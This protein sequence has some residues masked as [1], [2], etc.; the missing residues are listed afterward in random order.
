MPKGIRDLVT[1]HI[2][3]TVTITETHQEFMIGIMISSTGISHIAMTGQTAI[4]STTLEA[5]MVMRI[6]TCHTIIHIE[7]LAMAIEARI[8][9]LSEMGHRK[10]VR[11]HPRGQQNQGSQHTYQWANPPGEPSLSNLS[12]FVTKDGVRFNTISQTH[13]D[14]QIACTYL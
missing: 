13:Q 9:G 12:S 7:I 4:H 5:T 14:F 3:M 2:T 8:N 6:V 11:Q 1:G 10:Y